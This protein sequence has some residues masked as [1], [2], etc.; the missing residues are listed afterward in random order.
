MKK[1]SCF[2]TNLPGAANQSNAPK[3]YSFFDSVANTIASMMAERDIVDKALATTRELTNNFQLPSGSSRNSK[4]ER[5]EH[6]EDGSR[7]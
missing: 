6:H 5:E 1:K 2:L 7:Q 4:P 3:S